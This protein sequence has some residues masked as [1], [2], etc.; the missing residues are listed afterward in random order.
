MKQ[1][2]NISFIEPFLIDPE[3][4]SWDG[5]PKTDAGKAVKEILIKL[6][7]SQREVTEEDVKNA[8]QA[9]GSQIGNKDAYFE[10]IIDVAGIYSQMCEKLLSKSPT[11]NLP[12]PGLAK[13]RGLIHD[14][15]SIVAKYEGEFRGFK[16]AQ[17]DK[18][19]T[20]YFLF[21]GLGLE[22][23][24]RE[25]PMHCAYFEVLQM[26]AEE[27]GFPEVAMYENWTRALND[28]KNPLNFQNIQQ[29]FDLFLQGKSNLPLIALAVSD[30][31]DN[32]RPYLNLETIDNDFATRRDDI[33]KRY[34]YNK[35]AQFQEPTPLGK[36]LVELKGVD[37]INNYFRIVSDLLNKRA[38]K[39]KETNPD[40]YKK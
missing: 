33:L 13:V 29:E 11:L 12:E 18:Q 32:G 24:A 34:Y 39:Y 1:N 20:E 6:R 30:Y 23:F 31:L 37:R 7:E 8:V 27:K 2:Y 16:F 28:P 15:D 21:R 22:Q 36:A 9:N 4:V 38:N 25:V 5:N 40:L 3:L 17:H 10:H 19:L 35:K 14:L 26:I